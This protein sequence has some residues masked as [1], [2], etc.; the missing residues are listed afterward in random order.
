MR[1]SSSRPKKEGIRL[2][3]KVNLTPLLV[4]TTEITGLPLVTLIS[5]LARTATPVHFFC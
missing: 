3:E 1:L 4:V 5:E 2:L